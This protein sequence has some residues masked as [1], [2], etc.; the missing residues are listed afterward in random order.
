MEFP[1]QAT[2][3]CRFCRHQ[4]VKHWKQSHLFDKGNTVSMCAVKKC[5]CKEFVERDA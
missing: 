3:K 2:D 1:K 5:K 4:R